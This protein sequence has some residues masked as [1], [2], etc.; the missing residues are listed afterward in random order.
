MKKFPLALTLIGVLMSSTLASCSCESNNEVEANK[1]YSL[2]FIVD[3]TSYYTIKSKGNEIITLPETPKKDGFKFIGWYF[4]Q[5]FKEEF[6]ST[7]FENKE[8]TSDISLYAKFI[9]EQEL[10]PI[11]KMINFYVDDSLYHQI[12]TLG[13]EKLS[14]PNE[15]TKVNHQFAGWYLDTNY[16]N[17]F[18]ISVYETTLLND[19]ISVYAKFLKESEWTPIKKTITFYVNGQVYHQILTLG[20]EKLELPP[21]PTRQGETFNGWYLDQDFN[22]LFSIDKYEHESLEDSIEVY[23]KFTVDT[24]KV[25]FETNGGSAVNPI[26]TNTILKEPVTQK[27]GYVF[28]G[29]YKEKELINK[30]NFPLEVTSD[31]TLFAK[32]EINQVKKFEIDKNG[33]IIKYNDTTS[34]IVEIPN[35]IDGINVLELDS[36][37]FQN[38]KVIEEI[39]L[40]DTL[41]YIGYATFKGATSLKKVTIKGNIKSITSSCFENCSSLKEV[42]LP[43]SIQ[44]ISANSF[45]NTSLVSFIAP[46]NLT[47]IGNEAF[48]DVKTLTTLNLG[49]VKKIYRAAFEGCD[50]LKEVTLPDSLTDLN[51]DFVFFNCKNL[52]KV[53]MPKKSISITNTL[54]NGTKLYL[55]EA[56]WKNNVLYVGNYLVKVNDKYT[57]TSLTTNSDTKVIAGGAINDSI[58]EVK[59]NEGIEV[60][61]QNA[62]YTKSKVNKVNIPTSVKKIGHYAFTGTKVASDPTNVYK[63]AVYLDNWLIGINPVTT[64][65]IKNFV[66]K[67]GTRGISDGEHLNYSTRS[68]LA[69][70][71]LNNELL[72]IGDNAF[73]NTELTSVTFPKGLISIGSNA[74][75]GSK[76]KEV[77]LSSSTDVGEKAFSEGTLINRI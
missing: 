46:K 77:T 69:T 24:F 37:L 22:R 54:F 70:L 48:K 23:A 30:V 43:D 26:Q 35:N 59:L 3:G 56:N 34:K 76:I 14:L 18:D 11:K 62:F 53:N 65:N 72:Y 60:I 25:T 6:L 68:H 73:K 45:T 27:E 51:E 71:T 28:K 29:W 33:T 40:P 5:E 32:W 39:V 7:S 1:E 75:F 2:N 41:T 8:I 15:P 49:N 57:A 10:T 47:S 12:L 21:D 42:I 4:D 61:S 66:L 64:D 67:E 20:N 58:Q 38:N 13:N 19:S 9:K 16:S 55:N 63:D 17:A 31:L 74:F 44:N 52:E 50:G 36:E